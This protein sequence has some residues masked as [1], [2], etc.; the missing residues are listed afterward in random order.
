MSK[1]CVIPTCKRISHVLCHG[2]NQ[3]FCRE[4][5]IEHDYAINSQLNPLINEINLLDTR[6]KTINFEN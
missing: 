5:M 3:N 1:I 6:L 4:H 2:C